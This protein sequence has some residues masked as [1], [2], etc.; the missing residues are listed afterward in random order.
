MELIQTMNLKTLRVHPLAETTP[1]YTQA[2]YNA[3]FRDIELNGQQVAAVVYKDFIIDGRHRYRAL[4]ELNQETI[5]VTVLPDNT[6]D[7]ELTRIIHSLETR[8][9][10]TA[11]QLA[12]K[13][14][15]DYMDPKTTGTM[16]SFADRHGASLANINR[17]NKI[18]G[19]KA[20]QFMRPDIL[21]LLF[22]GEKF[23]IE[24]H[25][26]TDSLAAI[27]NFLRKVQLKRKAKLTGVVFD[28][29]ALS[30]SEK[31]FVDVIMLKV[32]DESVRVRRVIAKRLYSSI[33]REI[34][35]NVESEEVSE[36]Q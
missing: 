16:S 22:N 29:D 17:A 31:D 36:Q 19:T 30:E 8:R 11:S 28:T 13:A 32:A 27:E 14:W 5:K 6:T 12:I 25:I 10:E 21:E 9:H 7:A 20:K 18:G 34:E 1:T 4:S 3:L 24:D 2:Q 35:V 23:P 33:P 15:Y 26:E